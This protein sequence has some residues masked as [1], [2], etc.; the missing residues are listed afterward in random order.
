VKSE[1]AA[2]LPTRKDRARISR[3]LRVFADYYSVDEPEAA[4]RI[5]CRTLLKECNV[6]RALPIPLRP[7]CRRLGIRVVR[8]RSAGAGTLRGVDGRMEIWLSGDSSNWRRERFTIAHEI[9]H[10]LVF[11]AWSVATKATDLE[12]IDAHDERELE[13]LCNLGA[14]ELLMPTNALAEQVEALGVA[15]RG[16]QRLYDACLVSYE[17]MLY[18]IAEITPSSAVILWRKHARRPAEVEKLRVVT[19]YQRYQTSAHAPWLPKGCTVA[20][21]R[22]DIVSASYFGGDAIFSRDIVLS[23][24]KRE[25]LCVGVSTV[26][27]K[28]R[29]AANHLPLF[30]GARIIDEKLPEVDVV[31]F[32]ANR[33]MNN[34]PLFWTKL[35]EPS[36]C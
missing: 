19:S 35:G 5:A 34:H 29:T 9:A 3:R 2:E 10:V 17:T 22:P 7:L 23:L 13:S 12:L 14:A 11:S 20:H 15:P 8:R 4:M 36:K 27:P 6:G 18:R 32:V 21:V 25:T 33:I 24:S 16:L 1:G 31:L 28:P 30:E 26:L